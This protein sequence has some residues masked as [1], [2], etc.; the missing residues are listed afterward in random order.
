MWPLPT[1]GGHAPRRLALKPAKLGN[2]Q[3]ALLGTIRPALT[4]LAASYLIPLL[5]AA[6][7]KRAVALQVR[8]LGSSPGGMVISAWDGRE[9]GGLEARFL[10][11][12][13]PVIQTGQ[14]HLVY[15]VLNH[16]QP[17]K[18]D[19]ALS[20]QLARL[21]EMIV[22]LRHGVAPEERP[23]EGTLDALA[24]AI[25][26]HVDALPFPPADDTSPPPPLPSLAILQQAGVPVVTQKEWE[27]ALIAEQASRRSIQEAV[28]YGGWSWSHVD[29]EASR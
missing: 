1:C 8:T 22:I 15:P 25:G 19:A 27:H 3:T 6:T 21:N 18:P 2:F 26:F 17:T 13:A 28:K 12:I 23:A 5:S 20:V 10:A 7:A 14:Q 16:F 29:P 24:Q 11:L 9:F 4:S